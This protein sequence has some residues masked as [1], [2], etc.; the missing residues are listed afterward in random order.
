MR[1]VLALSTSV[2]PDGHADALSV[3]SSRSERQRLSQPRKRV[4][5]AQMTRFSWVP[6]ELP[7]TPN[8][9]PQIQGSGHQSIRTEVPTRGDDAVGKSSN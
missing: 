7:I 4:H 9:L 2:S 5:E 8:R 6:A 3:E 1:V